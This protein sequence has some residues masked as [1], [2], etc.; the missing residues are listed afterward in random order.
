MI[1]LTPPCIAIS[2]TLVRMARSLPSRDQ[3][4]VQIV[5]AAL[6]D[7]ASRS[8]E[9]LVCKLGC[10]QCCVGVFAINALDA[11]RLRHGLD[12]LDR[13]DPEKAER[14]RGRARASI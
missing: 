3:K 9:W 14:V 12:E 5:D 13:S 7:S 2:S 10:T 8:G 4:L 1:L 11:L 6:A